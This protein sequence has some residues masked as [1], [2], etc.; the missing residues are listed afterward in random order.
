MRQT[1]AGGA[2]AQS[3]P[4]TLT[5][6]GGCSGAPQPATKFF[7]Y[8][9]GGVLSLHWDPPASGAAPSTYLLNVSGSFVGTFPMGGRSFSV[10][11]PPGTFTFSI[12][13][14]NACG[15]SAPTATQT[16]SFP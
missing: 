10:A 14:T 4:V 13:A 7:A 8:K 12:V 2:S 3:S 15:A 11:A 5:F 1:N 9:A 16:V 6:P